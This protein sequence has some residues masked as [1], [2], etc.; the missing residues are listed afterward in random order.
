MSKLSGSK[1]YQNLMDKIDDL[2]STINIL[3]NTTNTINKL[4]DALSSNDNE[5][6]NAVIVAQNEKIKVQQESFKKIAKIVLNHL[7]VMGLISL[8]LKV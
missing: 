7:Q 1:Q 8:T 6:L 4:K 5:K 2:T 3:T